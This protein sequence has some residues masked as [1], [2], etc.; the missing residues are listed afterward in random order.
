MLEELSESVSLMYDTFD[1][2]DVVQTWRLAYFSLLDV[3]VW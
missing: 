3:L 1:T 2:Y